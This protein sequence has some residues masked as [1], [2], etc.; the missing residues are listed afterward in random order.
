MM[1]LVIALSLTLVS[2]ISSETQETTVESNSLLESL[3]KTFKQKIESTLSPPPDTPNKPENQGGRNQGGRQHHR[4]DSVSGRRVQLMEQTLQEHYTRQLVESSPHLDN[5]YLNVQDDLSSQNSDSKTKGKEPHRWRNGDQGLNGS[6]F[7]SPSMDS[8]WSYQW[9]PKHG[10]YQ[11]HRNDDMSMDIQFDLGYFVPWALGKHIEGVDDATRKFA[12]GYRLNF[13]EATVEL[14]HNGD[15][16]GDSIKKVGGR[17]LSVVVIHDEDDK[18][19]SDIPSSQESSIHNVIASVEEPKTC[20]YVIHACKP[21][22]PSHEQS[23]TNT[24]DGKKKVPVAPFSDSDANEIKQK[25]QRIHEVMHV[26]LHQTQAQTHQKFNPDRTTSLHVGLPPLPLSRI[27]AN[28][29]LIKE[30]FVHAYDSYMY[31]AYPASEVKPMTCQPAVFNLV[32]IP[33]LTLID[34]LD[35]LVLLGNYTEFA[36]SVERLR[37]LDK[38]MAEQSGL[39]TKNGLF[40]LNQNVSVFETNIR[41]LGGLLSAHQLA[42]AFLESKVLETHVWAE[43]KTILYGKTPE[44]MC[45]QGNSNDDQEKSVSEDC[46]KSSLLECRGKNLEEQTS[47]Q[48]QTAKHWRYDGFLLELAQDIGDRLL[49]AFQTRTG[50]PYGTI[51]LLSGIPEGE[52]TIASLAGGGTLSLEMELLSRLTGNPE[53]GR[54]AKLS[55]RALWMRRSRFN[56][57]GKHICTSRGEWTESLSGIGSNSDSFYEYLIKHYVLF[58]ED[59]DFWFQ[60]V[61]AYGGVHN[62]SRLGDWYGDVDLVRGLSTGG[63]AKKVFEALMAF[64]P[65]MQVL[66]G[67]LTPAARSLNSFFLVREFLGFLPERFNFEFWKADSSG[68]QHLLRPELLE[69]AYFLHRATKGFQQQFRARSNSTSVDSSGWQW[70]ADFALHTLEKLTRT[71]CGYASLR[72]LSPATTGALGYT[73]DKKRTKIMNEMP[74]YF[75]SETLKYLY[76]TFDENNMLHIDESRDWVFTTEAHPIHHPNPPTR[77]DKITKLENEKQLLMDRLRSRIQ[78]EGAMSSP[79]RNVLDNEKWTE[80]S[81]LKSF[82]KQI[83]PIVLQVGE[84]SSLRAHTISNG[85]HGA[86]FLKTSQMVEPFLAPEQV[87]LDLDFFNETQT[88]TNAA[89]MTFRKMGK[90]DSLARACPNFYMSDFLW[91]R[92]LNGG[93][94]D[95]ADAYRSIAHDA[96]S[97]SMSNFYM[98]GSSDALAMYGSGI[99]VA[100]LFNESRYCS[101]QEQQ[102]GSQNPNPSA[103]KSKNN[104]QNGPER[105]DMGGDLGEFEVSAFPG[106]SGFFIHQVKSGETLTTTLI[107]DETSA[108]EL[109]VFVMV[110][111]NHFVNRLEGDTNYRLNERSVVMSDLKGNS[112][113]CQVEIIAQKTKNEGKDSADAESTVARN[114]NVLAK[115]PCAPALFGPTHISELVESGGIV[116]ESSLSSPKVGDEHGC[117]GKGMETMPMVVQEEVGLYPSSLPHG[118]LPQDESTQEDADMT[119]RSKGVQMVQRGVCTFQDKSM[120]QKKSGDA[121]AV[122]VINSEDEEL[123]VM[124]GGGIDDPEYLDHRNYP[125]TVLVTKSDG[126]A[127]LAAIDTFQ[128][129]RQDDSEVFA[130]VSLIR[131]DVQILQTEAGKS[132]A[133]E[134][135]NYWPAVRASSESL[136][137]F[138]TGGWGVHAVQRS[139]DKAKTAA[140]EWQLFLLRF[141]T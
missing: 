65:G 7:F 42:E 67:E 127:I 52:T 24:V 77:K 90:A 84:A 69:S 106:G 122:I 62:E 5:Y 125:P 85:Q 100:Q 39:M 57:L 33:A 34:S 93:A 16:C 98:L 81:Q 108:H 134:G 58:P 26:Y 53:Y 45:K 110:F 48:N 124:S 40:A 51:N 11:G 71:E 55:A 10:V 136:Q 131:D 92:A 32:K 137:V 63:G 60:M 38:H 73:G 70:A 75:L 83:E 116:V 23:S 25:M 128:E 94:V 35:T 50:I 109:E 68:G 107:Q 6:L 138:A 102:K 130:R 36:R 139:G 28:L 21:S 97:S 86:Q 22:K 79:A 101:V 117:E 120:N 123:F 78:G 72:E 13:P 103:R 17:R 76:L 15:L 47:C 9:C 88:K 59:L 49:P 20:R 114:E 132:F 46:S 61:S 105:F 82:M 8:F 41:V 14:Y 118:T 12:T 4:G 64:Y 95:Y 140:L 31:H 19:C 80:A 104:S 44:C 112:Y 129:S 56:L 126:R 89:H 1:L 3:W 141:Q 29:Q 30:M 121:D 37:F 115:Y 113:I 27:E 96:E 133:I 74:S 54:A 87:F 135:N 99:H 91:I 66:L 119:C 2:C 111:S 18:L 43:D